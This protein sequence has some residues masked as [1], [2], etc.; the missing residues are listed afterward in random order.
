MFSTYFHFI[1]LVRKNRRLFGRTKYLAK[2]EYFGEN[3]TSGPEGL[4]SKDLV[5]PPGHVMH[6]KVFSIQ[7]L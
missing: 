5:N 3:F 6:H 1:F 2:A 4:V 7:Q